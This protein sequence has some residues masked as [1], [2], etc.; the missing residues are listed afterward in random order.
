MGEGG[1]HPSWRVIQSWPKPNYTSP[2]TR[3]WELS[4]LCI[5]LGIAATSVV[6]LRLHARFQVQKNAGLDDILVIA[7]MVCLRQPQSQIHIVL[8]RKRFLVLLSS[9]AFA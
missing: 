8:K 2:A 6:L 5:V 3:G 9:L 7:A 1:I 4:I